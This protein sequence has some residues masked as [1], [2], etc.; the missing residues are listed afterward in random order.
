MF[1][2]FTDLPQKSYLGQQKWLALRER[3]D[4]SIPLVFKQLQIIEQNLKT[5][6][7]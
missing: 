4:L 5:H 2:V 6:S 3:K 1:Q 7:L